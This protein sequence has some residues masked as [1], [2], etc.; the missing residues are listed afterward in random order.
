[1]SWAGCSFRQRA[2]EAELRFTSERGGLNLRA[3]FGVGAGETNADL[4]AAEDVLFA[5]ARRV[6][7]VDQRS[8]PAAVGRGVGS[9]IMER[10]IAAMDPA[11]MQH[12]HAGIAAADPVEHRDVHGIETVANALRAGRRDTGSQIISDRGHHRAERDTGKFRRAAFE[13][14]LL[15]PLPAL[16]RQHDLVDAEQRPVVGII[17][18]THRRTNDGDLI[19]AVIIAADECEG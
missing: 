15:T 9:D 14:N 5:L 19:A 4:I 18:V 7:A 8:L 10:C 13:M 3:G 2:S 12:H 6:F 1:M 17:I 16:Q 11:V